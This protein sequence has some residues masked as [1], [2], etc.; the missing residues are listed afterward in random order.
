MQMEDSF[1]ETP[2]N[3]DLR[4]GYEHWGR[5]EIQADDAHHSDREIEAFVH[6]RTA[7]AAR[8]MEEEAGTYSVQPVMGD[9]SD[10]DCVVQSSD[11]T[12]IV[13]GGASVV[14]VDEHSLSAARAIAWTWLLGWS[15]RNGAV[16]DS[17]GDVLDAE[18]HGRAGPTS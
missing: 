15:A 8:I 10:G 16:G 2:S 17:E 5:E 3:N 11:P 6:L 13:S 1:E 4:N 9:Y 14:A 7:T 18:R 12:E